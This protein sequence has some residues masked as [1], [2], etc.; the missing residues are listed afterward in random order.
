MRI[1]DHKTIKNTLVYTGL[2]D[3]NNDEYVLKIAQTADKAMILV[4][5]GFDY[6]YTT[7][8]NLMLFKKKT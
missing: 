3:F 1:P 6:I 5:T 7:P 2:I 4:E 8:E